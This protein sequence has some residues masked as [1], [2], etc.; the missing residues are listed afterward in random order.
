MEY[1]ASL[2]VREML[3]RIAQKLG[4]T[5]PPDFID[6]E[7]DSVYCDGSIRIYATPYWVEV[8][9][10]N[11]HGHYAKA[12]EVGGLLCKGNDALLYKHLDHIKSLYIA[13]HFVK[14]VDC[15]MQQAQNCYN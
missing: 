10:I 5:N 11:E 9:C 13:S 2:K 15:T 12:L 6:P 3:T 14:T 7:P 1:T 4:H 8:C